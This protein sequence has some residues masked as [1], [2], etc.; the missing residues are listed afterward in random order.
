MLTHVNTLMN[1]LELVNI[2]K[3]QLTSL[4]KEYYRLQERNNRNAFTD[5]TCYTH[6][7]VIEHLIQSNDIDLMTQ[8]LKEHCDSNQYQQQFGIKP[9]RPLIRFQEFVVWLMIHRRDKYQYIFNQIQKISTNCYTVEALNKTQNAISKIAGIE[10]DMFTALN[11]LHC[12][13]KFI[14]KNLDNHQ[15]NKNYPTFYD[16]S[17]TSN[18]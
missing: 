3:D 1:T 17:E 12:V 10:L 9:D 14:S 2:F 5:Q 8:C 13:H 7:K 15:T 18:E 4:I 16:I 6:L 11:D